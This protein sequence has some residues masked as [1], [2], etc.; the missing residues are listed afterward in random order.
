MKCQGCGAENLPTA[1]FCGGCGGGLAAAG[2]ANACPRCRAPNPPGCKFCNQCGTRLGTAAYEDEGKERRIVT[3][4]FADVSGFTSLAER[5]D[6]EEVEERIR[7][8]WARLTPV[9]E[10]HGGY[11]DKYIGD[12]VMVLFGAPTAHEDDPERAVRCAIALHHALRDDRLRLRIGVHTGEAIVGSVSDRGEKDYTAMGDTVNIASRLHTHTLPG[13]TV[14][15]AATQ[16]L[17]DGK[18]AVRALDPLHVKGKTDPI[19][20]FDVAGPAP[21]INPG[22]G[23]GTPF[24]GR[25]TELARLDSA[26]EKARTS[27]VLTAIGICGSPGVGKARLVAEW[28]AR[29]EKSRPDAVF[30]SGEAVPYGGEPCRAVRAAILGRYGVDAEPGALMQAIADD[31]AA[32][33]DR[34]PELSSGFIGRLFGIDTGTRVRHLDPRDVRAAA[35]A[36]LRNLLIGLSKRGPVVLVLS[37][38]QWADSGT[39]DFVENLLKSPPAAPVVLV[40]IARPEA[41]RERPSLGELDR[42]DLLPHSPEETSLLIRAILGGR[43]VP[44]E[45]E[46]LLHHRSEGNAF[47]LEEMIRNLVEDGALAED[48][49]VE[50]DGE[51]LSLSPAR[52]LR[53]ARPLEEVRLPHTV[54]GVVTARIDA[55]PEDARKVL[56]AAAVAGRTFSRSILERVLGRGVDEALQELVR[57]ELIHERQAATA[58]DREFAFAHALIPEVAYREILKRNRKALHRGIAEALEEK[59]GS[60]RPLDRL[61]AAANHYEQAEVRDRAV[62][63]FLEAADRARQ[64]YANQEALSCYARVLAMEE[65]PEAL[66]GRADVLI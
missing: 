63:L 58:G 30:L 3:V 25:A 48:Q 13:R 44:T 35:F 6:P 52:T 47:Y 31:L 33:G 41:F 57:R 66:R 16:R 22:A 49:D 60:R 40:V 7:A 18:F 15:S 46:E 62:A 12:A 64:I 14:I 32:G 8:C 5:L 26:L 61:A 2:P 23:V 42:V 45:L 4:L 55:L 65:R 20:A 56:K 28:Q 51:G 38:L 59:L 1:R 11:V 36:A 19:A 53:L 34:S 37:E 24:V 9:I 27:Q 43:G 29:A 21:R 50:I 39:M 54:Q 17:V 10:K